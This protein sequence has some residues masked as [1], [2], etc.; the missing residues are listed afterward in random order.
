MGNP[1][2]SRLYPAVSG[3]YPRFHIY[4][5]L[6]PRWMITII[7]W[8][9]LNGMKYHHEGSGLNLNLGT[10]TWEFC[11]GLGFDWLHSLRTSVL[12]IWRWRTGL[13]IL[14]GPIFGVDISSRTDE[15]MRL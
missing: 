2:V 5:P 7:T 6:K 9:D 12:C 15:L 4:S 14:W 8:S 3:I 13:F 11:G 10:P 1:P